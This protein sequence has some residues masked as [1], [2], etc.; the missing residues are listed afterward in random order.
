MI[1]LRDVTLARGATR[2]LEHASLT[3]HAGQKVGVVGAN[4]CGKSTLFALLRGEIAADAGDV[5]LPASWRIAHVAQETPAVATPA[6]DYVQ[7]GDIE[8]RA[9]EAALAA[10]DAAHDG[11]ALAELHHRYEA[12]GGYAARARAAE[13]LAGLGVASARH[14]DPVASFSGGWR[15]RLNLAQALNARAD[16]L[17]LDEPTNHLDLDAVLW[18]E[19]WL[20]RFPGTLLLITHDRDFLDGVA[21]VIVHFDARTLKTY[22]GNY[23]QFERERAAALAVQRA[24]YARQQRQI[25]HLK[26]FVDRFRAKATKA[27]QAQSRLRT[28]ERMEIIAAAHADSPFEFA[29]APSRAVARE[30]VRLEDATLRYGDAA[31]VFKGLDVAIANG[32]R[33]G[34]LGPNGAGKSTLVKALAGELPLASGR[35]STAQ[36][37]VIGYFAQHQ[38]EQLDGGATPL[39]TLTRLDPAAREQELRDFL[40]GFDFRGDDVNAPIA[41]FSGGEKARLVLATIVRS[42][43]DLLILDEPTNHLDIEMREA[44][45]E[46]LQDYDGALVV[47]AHDRHL[48]AATADELWLVDDGRVAPFDGDLDDYRDY[49]L[50]ARS[51]SATESRGRDAGGDRRQQKREE[52]EARQRRHDARK[53]LVAEQST[54]EGEI[55]ALTAEKRELDTW[56]ASA[57]AYESAARERLVESIARQGELTWQLA[58]AESAWLELQEKLDALDSRIDEPREGP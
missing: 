30:L 16:L 15:M 10:A 21:R 38:L 42:R 29:F 56:L 26:S 54:I 48:L 28:L 7:N 20:A 40:G 31:P 51:R 23:S 43:P 9:V 14:A 22:G 33:I 44:L 12:I 19:Q 41:R 32:E 27:R 47:V 52:A 24:A 55:D 3:V 49:V 6:I 57:E 5:E 17:L 35:R 58:R 45:T 18:L 8:L 46:A 13:L 37:L 1:R 36:N 4:G 39:A 25:A 50:S 11:H 34:L 53:P 2:L